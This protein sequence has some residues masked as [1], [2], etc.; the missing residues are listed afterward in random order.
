MDDELL[1]IVD[2]QAHVGREGAVR[3]TRAVLQTLAERL[4]ASQA[5][6]LCERLPPELLEWLYTRGGPVPFDVDELLRRVAEREGGDI[7]V[8]TVEWH[9]RAVFATLPE[10]LINQEFLLDVTV[11]LPPEYATLLPRP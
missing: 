11:Q 7:D 8:T 4:S 9:T 10:A 5:R 3:T 1:S 6:K 2:H